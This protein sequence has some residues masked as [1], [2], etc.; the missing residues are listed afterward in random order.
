MRHIGRRRPRHNHWHGLWDVWSLIMNGRFLVTAW[1]CQWHGCLILHTAL[2]VAMAKACRSLLEKQ[3][4]L[5]RCLR[6]INAVRKEGIEGQLVWVQPLGRAPE[7][8]T[9]GGDG[10]Y[11]RASCVRLG[12]GKSNVDVM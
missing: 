3:G 7:R 10:K 4:E 1:W 11:E 9:A 2:S 12:A 5:Q 8:G 6:D